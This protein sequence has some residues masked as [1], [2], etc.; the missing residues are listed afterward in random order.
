[1]PEQFVTDEIKAIRTHLKTIKDRQDA[2]DLRQ[3]ERDRKIDLIV[4]TLIDNDFNANSG[5]ISEFRETQKKVIL[6]DLYFKVLIT[7]VIAG[8]VLTGIIKAIL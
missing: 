2:D 3:I 1:M 4:N 7:I 8:G 6:H 5:L